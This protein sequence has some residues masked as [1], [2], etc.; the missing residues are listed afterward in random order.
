MRSIAILLGCTLLSGC[1]MWDQFKESTG[2]TPETSSIELVIEASSVLNVREGGQSSPVILRVHEL[3]SPVLFRS[4]DFFALFENDKT[5]LGD[6]YI[7]RYEYQMQPGEK[8]HEFL[9]LDPTT[10]AVGFSVAF[11]DIDGSSWRKVEVIEE[12]SEYYIKLKLEG[13]ELISDKTRGI[14]Q[15]YF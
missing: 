11:R 4:L 5:S 9:E 1:S 15:V 8:I 6:E 7:K 12:K 14:E 13:S 2:I 10:R 3:T